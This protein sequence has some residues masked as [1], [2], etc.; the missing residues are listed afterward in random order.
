[1]LKLANSRDALN[2]VN[3]QI[4]GPTPADKIAATL[5][6]MAERMQNGQKGGIY[7]YAGQPDTS[8]AGFAT[9]IFRQAGK[10]VCVTGIPTRDYPT[11][12]IRPLNS[13]LDCRKIKQDSESTRQIGKT[14]WP[15]Y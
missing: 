10:D 14:G 11:P 13:R 2:V 6:K 7:H 3:D 12:A 5:L 9:E 15:V 8:W 4:G 1:M